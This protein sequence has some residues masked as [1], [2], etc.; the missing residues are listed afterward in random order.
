M[1]PQTLMLMLFG[2]Y[3]LDQ[4]VSLGAGSI[5]EVLGRAGVSA[6][7]TRSTLSRSVTRDL[8]QRRPVGRKMYFGL[9]GR[10]T[11]ILR[12]GRARIWQDGAVND[13]WDG[14]WTLLSFSLPESMQR[15]R[16]DLRSRLAWSGFGPVQGGLWIAPGDVPAQQIVSELGLAAHAR[17][18]RQAR[19]DDTT[20]IG[21][22]IAD[23]YDLPELAARY[24][25]FL[26]RWE[27]ADQDGDA[28]ATRLALIGEWLDA[29]RRDP[30][31]PVEHLPA[32][33]P[34]VRAQKVFRDLE[35]A[36]REPAQAIADGL[37]DK[38][39]SSG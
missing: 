4:G 24:V 5:I 12:D 37:L 7:A 17:V 28:L 18:F 31:L 16:H 6:H 15:E 8:L 3:A 20:D 25:D 29:I 22:L 13:R 34:A 19:A 27:G 32:D 10:S 11:A 39:S 38:L 23:A 2:T 21:A 14:T 36:L 30:R 26:D 1:Q 35:A 9:T 33:W